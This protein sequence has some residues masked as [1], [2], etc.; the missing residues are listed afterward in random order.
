MKEVAI[1]GASGYVGGELLTLCHRH[2][3]LR[4]TQISS[5]HSA[6]RLVHTVHPQLRKHL[7]LRFIKRENLAQ[8]DILFLALPHGEAARMIEEYAVLA[9]IV[10]D[11]SADFRLRN[12]VMHSRWYG[13]ETMPLTWRDQFVYG[14][15][16][17]RREQ[18]KD[19]RYISGVGCNA[20]AVNLA[21]LPL[22][23]EANLIDKVIADIKVGSSEGGAKVS[24]A[25]HHPER[26]RAVRSFSLTGH[27]HQG[28]ICQELKLDEEQLFMTVTA[29]EM[30]RG[31]LATCH[32]FLKRDVTESALMN[33]Y[34]EQYAREPFIRIVRE[35]QGLYRLP[36]P[37]ILIGTNYCDIGW[38]LDDHG[39]RLVVLSALDN[40]VKGSAGSAIQA[41]NIACGFDETAGL[42][43]IGLR[44]V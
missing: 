17:M 32:V 4:V 8:S 9:D 35:R 42:D 36:E 1:V 2:P 21:L 11:T 29:I 39:K 33:L 43:F 20:T 3:E 14:L 37:K 6:G 10:I 34:R 13:A 28:E 16:E 18:L 44:T 27:R 12:P 25:S 24:A 38:K 7:N 30:V 23:K 40:L 31:V 41:M 5:E 15:A 26:S 19:A 22:V